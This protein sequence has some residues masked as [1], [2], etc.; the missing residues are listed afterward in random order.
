MNI[1]DALYHTVHD[2]PGG[3]E[4]IALRMGMLAGVLRNKICPTNTTNKPTFAEAL[5]V[6][7]LTGDMR[8]LHAF[9]GELGYVCIKVEGEVGASD[10]AVLEVVTQGLS[11]H[12]N[13]GAAVYAA[14]VD[15]RISAAELKQ[16]EQA[17]FETHRAL[18]ELRSK[19]K[20]MS[21]PS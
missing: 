11:A 12:G 21:E 18:E 19:M 3:V 10:M 4:G 2:A 6:C 13:V 17:V 5:T 9:A 14:L 7:E 16:I 1:L 20:S 15:G 8:P